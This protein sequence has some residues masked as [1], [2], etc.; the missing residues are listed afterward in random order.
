MGNLLHKVFAQKG[1]LNSSQKNGQWIGHSNS[2]TRVFINY[3]E[4]APKV[5]LTQQPTKPNLLV[6]HVT[7]STTKFLNDFL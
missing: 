7:A 6:K 1:A 5:K 4:K 2:K 3:L